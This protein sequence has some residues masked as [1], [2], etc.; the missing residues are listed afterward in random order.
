LCLSPLLFE[1]PIQTVLRDFLDEAEST[2]IVLHALSCDSHESFGDKDHLASAAELDRE[3]QRVVLLTSATA[4]VLLAT[5]V[6]HGDK[7][8]GQDGFGME[9]CGGSCSCGLLPLGQL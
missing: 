6:D 7:A 3:V 4:A 5:G 2:A 8:S 1:K 9:Q